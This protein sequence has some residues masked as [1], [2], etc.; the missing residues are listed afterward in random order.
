MER[1]GVEVECQLHPLRIHV[2]RDGRRL[3]R[4]LHAWVCEGEVRDRFL[5]LTEG[6][7]AREELAFPERAVTATVLA[8]RPHE[9]LLA[10]K[11]QG[12]RAAQLRIA[13]PGPE[14]VVFELHAEG[15]PLRLALEWD[16]RPEEHFNG[17]GARHTRDRRPP[18]ARG[19]ARR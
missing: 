3:L 2:R 15:A 6:V 10:L 8:E 4:G 13:L 14:E 19:P 9:L 7:I 5:Q 18:R 17:L 1:D 11:L 16:A 12:G